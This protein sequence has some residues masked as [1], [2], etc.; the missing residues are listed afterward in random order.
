[1]EH[2]PLTYADGILRVAKMIAQRRE[3]YISEHGIY[4]TATG[5]TE[6]KGTGAEYVEELISIEEDIRDMAKGE[7]HGDV[8]P[9]PQDPLRYVDLGMLYVYKLPRNLSNGYCF[10][11]GVPIEFTNVD[12]VNTPTH[13]DQRQVEDWLRQRI[14]FLKAKPGTRFLSICPARPDLTFMFTKGEAI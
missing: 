3:T 1:M 6:F 10:G 9:T 13:F 12:W 4:D 7:P 8:N 5:Q 2:K 11:P 14:Y